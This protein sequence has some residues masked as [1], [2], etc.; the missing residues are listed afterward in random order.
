MHNRPFGICGWHSKPSRLHL[1][2]RHNGLHPTSL[3]DSQVTIVKFRHKNK[4][5]RFKKWLVMFGLEWDS[6]WSCVWPFTQPWPPPL[7]LK[8]MPCYVNCWSRRLHF[9]SSLHS[10]ASLPERAFPLHVAWQDVA[11]WRAGHGNSVDMCETCLFCNYS[12]LDKHIR[13]ELTPWLLWPGGSGY[14]IGKKWWHA[15]LVGEWLTTPIQWERKGI[16]M[17]MCIQLI[18][19]GCSWSS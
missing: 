19:L 10:C 8:Y 17:C 16:L 15:P 18:L 3:P 13:Q 4:G 6:F 1:G 12:W 2:L 7:S 14:E 5:V 11:S 9:A